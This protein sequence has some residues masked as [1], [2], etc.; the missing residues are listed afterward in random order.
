MIV[1]LSPFAS[2]DERLEARGSTNNRAWEESWTTD[3][4]DQVAEQ[5]IAS[6]P[7]V[8]VIGPGVNEDIGLTWVEAFARQ[9]T[10]TFIVMVG[11][12]RTELV[13]GAMRAGAAA[14]R[15]LRRLGGA[16]G[17]SVSNHV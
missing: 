1:F 11:D 5:V 13:V 7:L 16:A 3:S 6:A 4:P 2:F 15:R 17:E 8:V 12:M 10:D 14:R 9:R